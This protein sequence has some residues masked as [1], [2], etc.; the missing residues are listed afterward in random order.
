MGTLN[1]NGAGSRRPVEGRNGLISADLCIIGAGSG[2]LS[3][4]AGA[5]Q[6][7]ASVVLVEKG[8]MG[9]DCLNTGCVP[10]KSLI[11]AAHAAH[12]VRSG[13][14]FG[15]NGHEPQIDFAGVHAHVHDVISGIAPHDS[16]GR[17]E[18]L[19]VEVI[20]AA[21]RF[22][23]RNLLDVGGARI[24][25]RRFVI[26]TGSRAQVPAIP[27][28]DQV[29][30]LTNES[31]FEL[32]DQPEHLAI[33]G[34][35]PIGIEIAQA[36]R[37]LGSRVT[38]IE[39]QGILSR[40]EPEA[41]DVVRKVLGEEGIELRENADILSVS[42]AGNRIQIFVEGDPQPV[43]ST[44]LLVAAGRVPNI[45]DL[46]LDAAGIE[47]TPRGI[48]VDA[49]LRT[50]NRKVFAIGDV[51]GGPQFTHIA[52]YHAGI[53]IRN[54]LFGIPAKAGYRALPWV[55]YTDPELAHVGLTEAEARKAGCGVRILMQRF[56]DNDRARTERRTSGLAKVVIDSRNRI[57]GATVVGPHAGELISLWGLAIQANL[58]IGQVASMIAPYPT[59]SEISK[60]TAGSAFT[61]ALFGP[62]TRRVVGLIQRVLP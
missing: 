31:V 59:L 29:G 36:F 20:K 12:T 7:G 40:D 34:G 25:G 24:K 2:G 48:K 17:F 38:V 4:A 16:A 45:N 51:A 11:A 26:A 13:R 46:G 44:H 19:G 39:K 56:S 60:R 18:A 23:G 53:V 10:S 35:G 52:G 14:L 3:V 33:L 22:V 32:T 1:R 62:T 9:G 15:V 6:M 5:A 57:L 61:P 58:R 30:Y 43:T 47:T 54:A 21:G 55:T 37:R 42:P 28:L 49:R 41:V 27:G 8:M 50:S